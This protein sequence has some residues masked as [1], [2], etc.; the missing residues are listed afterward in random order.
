MTKLLL[1]EAI[2]IS[3]DLPFL[4]EEGAVSGWDLQAAVLPS[5]ASAAGWAAPPQAVSSAAAE[6]WAVF[7]ALLQAVFG[8][9][10]AALPP[11]FPVPRHGSVFVSIA[12][13]RRYG[14]F[15]LTLMFPE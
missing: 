13:L 12:A 5:A 14:L 11:G 10:W 1:H 6:H 8:E 4:W 3:S 7:R 15:F 9:R 2:F